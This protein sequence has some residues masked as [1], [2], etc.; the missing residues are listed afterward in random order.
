MDTKGAILVY[1]QIF[2]IFY[3]AVVFFIYFDKQ[4]WQI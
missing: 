2:P 3:Y 1:K 4:Q